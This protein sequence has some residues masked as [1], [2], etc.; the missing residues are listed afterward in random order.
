MATISELLN[1]AVKFHQSGNLAEAEQIYREI[2]TANPRHADAWHLLGLV[3]YQHGD[4]QAALEAI[5]RAIQL[6]PSQASYHNHLGEVHRAMRRWSEAE[7][8]CRR[9]VELKV[10]FAIAHNT[11]GAVLAEQGQ[12]EQAIISYRQAVQ[13]K[14]DFA[15]AH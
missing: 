7:A 11:L 15:Q 13:H 12:I 3:T 4:P 9:A 5:S 14:P 2:L 1:A 6:D 10:D 8:C